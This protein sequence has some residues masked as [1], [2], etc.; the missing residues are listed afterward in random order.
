MVVSFRVFI[1]VRSIY[2]YIDVYLYTDY[3]DKYHHM[4]QWLD[5]VTAPK[6]KV[7]GKKERSRFRL[8]F[9]QNIFCNKFFTVNSLQCLKDALIILNRLDN[10]I[11]D[12]YSGFSL[13]L[14]LR[15]KQIIGTVCIKKFSQKFLKKFTKHY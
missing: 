3:C 12:I 2:V 13:K 5:K 7:K 4:P 10:L 6:G 8:I 15:P 9:S 11:R 1:Y 14:C